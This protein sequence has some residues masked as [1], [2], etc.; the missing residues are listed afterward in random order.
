MN[1]LD[2]SRREESVVPGALV[3]FSIDGAAFG[4]P[5]ERVHE[6]IRVDA[7]TRVPHAPPR[8]RGLATFRGRLIPVIEL[9]AVLGRPSV[10][11]TRESRIVTVAVAGRLLGLLVERAT[12]VIGLSGGV[13]RAVGAMT[14]QAGVGGAAGDAPAAA[15]DLPPEL[16]TWQGTWYGR[17]LRVLDVDRI[18]EAS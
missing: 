11:I 15:H 5:V 10:A 1:E 4:I 6:V 17:P 7:I 12:A 2:A 18:A 8:L 13:S 9:A 14:E 16:V 3:T